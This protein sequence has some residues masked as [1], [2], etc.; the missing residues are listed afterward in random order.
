MMCV[1]VVVVV[2]VDDGVSLHIDIFTRK[3]KGKNRKTRRG[4]RESVKI[5]CGL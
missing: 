1:V 5:A 3:T 4:R 2:V